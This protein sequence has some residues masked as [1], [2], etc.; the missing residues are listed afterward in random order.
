VMGFTELLIQ[1]E[2]RPNVRADLEQIRADAGRAAKIVHN[3]LLFARREALERSVGDL[4][5]IVR[6]TVSLRSFELRSG[7]IRLEES[8]SHDVPLIAA[9]REQVQQVIVNLLL[10]AEQALRADRRPG[11][12]TIRTGREGDTA[13]VEVADDG[14]GVPPEAVGRIFEPFFTTKPAGEGTG[15]GLSVSMG[16]AKAHGGTLALLPSPRGARF[17]MTLPAAAVAA[18]DLTALEEPA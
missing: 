2:D 6:S 8:F 11:V 18:M 13:F 4:N 10:N 5:E 17:R 12:I 14:P 15:L 1:A 9:C 7:Q 3:L 16:I